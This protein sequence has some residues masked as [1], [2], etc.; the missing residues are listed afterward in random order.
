M[1]LLLGGKNYTLTESLTPEVKQY[2]EDISRPFSAN[3]RAT[4]ILVGHLPDQ[5]KI[6]IIHT[7]QM[8][9]LDVKIKITKFDSHLAT[10]DLIKYWEIFL[11]GPNSIIYH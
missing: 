9:A 3:V 4:V 8:Y 11:L 6:V 5:S 2:Y 1:K 10:M 7:A